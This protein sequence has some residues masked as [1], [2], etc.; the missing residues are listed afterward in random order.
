ME[1]PWGVRKDTIWTDGPRLDSGRVGD[2]M[3]DVW[4]EAA[5]ESPADVVNRTYLRET[6]LDT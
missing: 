1:G 3:A 5:A 4:A 6:S 2:E